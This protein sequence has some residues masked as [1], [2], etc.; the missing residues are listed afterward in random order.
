VVLTIPSLGNRTADFRLK[1]EYTRDP[2][3]PEL[4]IFAPESGLKDPA[5]DRKPVSKPG[6]DAPAKP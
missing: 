1:E 4:R 6:S 3:Y 2:A 5:T